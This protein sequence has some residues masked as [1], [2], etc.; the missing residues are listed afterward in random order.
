MT[1][2]IAGA[3]YG[4]DGIPSQWR[5]TVEHHDLL[6]ALAKRLWEVTMGISRDSV[7]DMA[8]ES[9]TTIEIL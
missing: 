8:G 3:Y 5:E 6:D 9:R 2:A 4:N 7:D 1:G